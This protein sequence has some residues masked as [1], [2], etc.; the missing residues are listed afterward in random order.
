M[1]QACELIFQN[2]VMD[3]VD[4]EAIFERFYTKNNAGTGRDTGL[5]LAIVKELC[6]GMREVFSPDR[7]TDIYKSIRFFQPAGNRTSVP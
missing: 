6:E 3:E 2:D 1:D 4:A 7:S 5:G